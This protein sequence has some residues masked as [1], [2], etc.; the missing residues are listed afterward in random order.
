MTSDRQ[1]ISIL[2]ALILILGFIAGSI[3]VDKLPA[4][5]PAYPFFSRF[6]THLGLDLQGG[7]HLL[8]EAD[9]SQVDSADAQSAIAG[10]R[11]VIEKRVNALGISE[12]LVQT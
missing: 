5:W 1:K 10:V 8:Y 4:W 7:A 11:D 9:T 2:F 3:F 12:P 6:R